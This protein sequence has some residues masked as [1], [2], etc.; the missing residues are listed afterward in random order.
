MHNLLHYYWACSIQKVIIWVTGHSDANTTS[1][2]VAES[3]KH[4]LLS[5]DCCTLQISMDTDANGVVY[6]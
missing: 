3:Y 5:L 2:V 1:L 4:P 6:I